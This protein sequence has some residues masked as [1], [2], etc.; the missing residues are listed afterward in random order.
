M[1]RLADAIPIHFF[2]RDRERVC[3]SKKIAPPSSTGPAGADFEARVGATQI[4]AMLKGAHARGL[5]D[6]IIDRVEFQRAADGFPL[7]DVVVHGRDASGAPATLQI[8]VKREISFSPNDGVFKDVVGEMA[9][10]IKARAFFAGRNIIAIATAKATG[11]ITGTYQDLLSRAR[12]HT[13]AGAFMRHLGTRKLYS[14]DMR[15]FVAT[16]R[17]HLKAHG[18]KYDD[19]TVWQILRRLHIHFY[20]FLAKEGSEN[21]ANARSR[22]A[23]ILHA[24]AKAEASNLW[25]ALIIRTM[26]LAADGGEATKQSLTEHFRS[27]FQFEGDPRYHAVRARVADAATLALAD[28]ST[29]VHGV[30]LP[31]TKQVD[32]VRAAVASGTRFIEIRGEAGLGKSALLKGFAEEIAAEGRVLV[33][34]PGRV[35]A[36]GW[37]AM[38]TQLAF[39]GDIDAFLRNL[40]ADGGGWLFIDN[41]DFYTADEQATVNDLLRAASKVPGF[42]VVATARTRFGMDTGSW[43]APEAVTALGRADPVIVQPIDDDELEMLREAEPRL[44]ALLAPDHPASAVTRN[45]YLLS[46]LLKLPQGAPLPITEI[47]MAAAWWASAAGEA[48]DATLRKRGRVLRE[49][50]TRAIH[51]DITFDV[52]TL[53]ETAIDALV[54]SEALSDFGNDRV[55][56][57]HD[58]LRDW[59]VAGVLTA[60]PEKFAEL[61]LASMGSPVQLR[62]LEL[63][64][65]TPIETAANP[66]A[67][68]KILDVVSGDGSHPIWRRTML[69]A[70]IHSEVTKQ[71]IETM[72]DTLLADDA[73][74]LRELIPIMLAVDVRPARDL[75]RFGVDPSLIPVSLNIPSGPAWPHLLTWLLMRGASLPPKAIP[76]VVELY[77]GWC[78]LG[79][80]LPDDR[81]TPLIVMQFKLWLTEI[82]LAQ[83][84]TDW[85][86]RK[87]RPEP[88]AGALTNEQLERI[89]EDARIYL[90]L[91]AIRAPDAA[92]AYLAHVQTLK[93]KEPIYSALMKMRGSLGQ[94]APDELAAITL[95]YLRKPEDEDDDDDNGFPGRSRSPFADGALAHADKDFLPEA[96]SQ[97]PFYDLLTHAPSVGLK[98]I[99]HLIDG[100]IAH[101]TDG[102]DAGED[103][104]VIEM[105][106]GARRFP[107]MGT[108][109]WSEHSRYYSVTSALMALETWGHERIE[110]GDDIIN[111]INDVVGEGEAPAAYVLIAIHLILSHWPESAAAGVPFVGCP[112]LLSLDLSRPVQMAFTGI[113]LF[114]FGQLSKEPASG[115][116]LAALKQR[117]S[118]RLSLDSLL[119]RYALHEPVKSERD[120]LV[121]LLRAASMRLGKHQAGDDRSDP[122][123]MAYLALNLID[124]K[125]WNE[126]THEV[127]G[128]VAEGFRYNP[129]P[130]EIAHF[131]P[132][133]A[134]VAAN[135][136][137][138]EYTTKISLLID[139]PEKSSAELA[140]ALQKWAEEKSTSSRIP[141]ALD[142]A[143]VG[144]AMIAMRDGE[145]HLRADK[146]DWAEQQFS[147]AVGGKPDVGGRMRAGM[148]YNPVAMAFAGRA[149]ALRATTLTRDDYKRLL[150]MAIVDPAA[151]RGAS[152]AAIAVSEID[153][154]LRRSILRVAFTSAVYFW[155]PWDASSAVKR[156]ADDDLKAAIAKALDAE[157]QWLMDGGV[158]PA[159]PRFAE[160]EIRTRV[161]RRGIRIGGKQDAE[162]PRPQRDTS[163][164]FVDHQ[165]AALWLSGLLSK[166]E[167]DAAWMEAIETTYAPWT[168][169]ANGAGLTEDDEV[170]EAPAEWNEAFFSVMTSNFRTRSLEEIG[171]RLAPLFALP[172]EPFF[173]L[174]EDVL[175]QIDA[176]F[177]NESAIAIDAAVA[178]RS[179]F[180]DRLVKSYGWQRLR[181]SRSTGIDIHLGPAVARLFF[182]TYKFRQAPSC[183]LPGDFIARS[184]PFTPLL[185]RQAAAAP[186]LYVALCVMSW[187]EAA[188]T[189]EHLPL[190]VEFAAAAMA[191]RPDDK[192]FWADHGMG[193][194]ICH[195]LAD[196]FDVDPTAFAPHRAVIDHT[197]AHLVA[198]GIVEARHL[199]IKLN[200][201]T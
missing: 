88:F 135:S 30:S 191:A 121:A 139:H 146:R 50:G 18:A 97:G 17:G 22:A 11:H 195:W 84:W 5:P 119:S 113:D 87:E 31:R 66:A 52:S 72:G 26:E 154:R 187:V 136:K 129:P 98:L 56:F 78:A 196:R 127:D 93:R 4:L 91:F 185:Q 183:Y 137:D 180:A 175:F 34:A 112:E 120:R 102:R 38:R 86:E 32:A 60:T 82:E 43:L 155:H 75:L 181:Q 190:V 189:N 46:R 79:M 54:K 199:E 80:F 35:A 67:W 14:D 125:N 53:D 161:R 115:P 111:V 62:G 29:T 188:P 156:Q 179:A 9:E 100:V 23:D 138:L 170:N 110:K 152:A 150:S 184:L 68:R 39:C 40:A 166:P 49:L 64:A 142:Q 162:P 133:Q 59:A 194:R 172:D 182:N 71:S 94:A 104:L 168:F 178:I 15:I 105:P 123:L 99:R 61:P 36:R 89:E 164:R 10:A 158:E 27:R 51:G 198:A 69:L 117:V 2:P 92:K 160:E 90:A 174:M 12:N 65:R 122:R 147:R 167:A 157:L 197:V 177:F 81:L 176:L 76:E 103:A 63:A 200:G 143:V 116:R 44:H 108:Y 140:A 163:R 7:D 148:L 37:D 41:L 106:E 171:A 134:K 144:A 173:D 74:L 149:F 3:L 47:D 58:V 6:V 28:I 25:D 55:A 48:T 107:W 101:D 193:R 151:A 85:R 19:E 42:T 83:D 13:S 145:P 131:E 1:A 169:A 118:R 73:A 132:L 128:E 8:Q 33:L 201:G 192:A 77:V 20:D 96:P 109:G 16:L 186:C 45:L 124:P 70:I 57:R 159:W 95:D 141:E 126:G 114:G 24:D 130:D 165:V 21:E 153:P